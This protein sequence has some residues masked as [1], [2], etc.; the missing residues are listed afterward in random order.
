MAIVDTGNDVVRAVK[1][2]IERVGG[3]GKFV[4]TGDK[5]ILKPNFVAPRNSVRGATTDFQVI[6]AVAEEVLRIGATP[7]LFERPGMEYD[8]RAVYDFLGVWAFADENNIEIF[9]L[10][11]EKIETVRVNGVSIPKILT[12]SKIINL[13]KLKTHVITEVTIALKNPMGLLTEGERRKMHVLGIHRQ[14]AKMSQAIT[15]A[16]NIVD[17]TMA[18]DGD[19]AVYGDAVELGKI[20]IGDDDLAVDWVCCDLM[21]IAPET[22]PYIRLI[23]EKEGAPDIQLIGD[24]P[25]SDYTF[26]LPKKGFIYQLF[27]WGLYAAD[28]L[29]QFISP[30]HF[31]EFMYKTGYFGSRPEII[32]EKCKSCGKCLENCPVSALDLE[33]GNIDYK[34]CLR[35]LVCYETCPENA[36]VVKG[37]SKPNLKESPERD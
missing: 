3:I 11:E 33:N 32:S 21:Q 19:G 27:Y 15:P 12:E 4:E 30:D 23:R 1:A 29:F 8:F 28:Y 9:D 16:L 18:M 36:I 20:I 34:K 10:P 17:A 35:C 31:N 7:I 6:Q 14:I 22:V 2:G 25:D 37:F 24:S 5:V 13:P 26:R